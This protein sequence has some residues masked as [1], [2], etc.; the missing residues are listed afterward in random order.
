MLLCV[1]DNV[2]TTVPAVNLTFIT[3]LN[4]KFSIKSQP[5]SQVKTAKYSVSYSQF[6]HIYYN[7]NFSTEQSMARKNNASNGVF[8]IF[9]SEL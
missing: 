2:Y 7:I 3:L 9:Y 1:Q 4:K 6:V 8:Q 5:Q